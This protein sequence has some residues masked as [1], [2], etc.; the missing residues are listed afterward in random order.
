[1]EP[2]ISIVT[3]GVADMRRS[4]R[5]YREG[6]GF[7]TTARDDAGWAI[8]RTVGCRFALFPLTELAKDIAQGMNVTSGNFCGITLAHNVRS[9]LEV[10]AV[11]TL[12]KAAGARI[13]KPG[14][15]T[16]WGGYSGYFADPDG[17][18][19]EIAWGEMWTFAADGSLCGG[20]LGD[21][22]GT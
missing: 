11:L 4:I 15:P 13:L 19:W 16:S 12:A 2:R 10:D 14:Q 6:L 1:M 7:T 18:P 5:F 20:S 21:A 8:F 9:K 17:Y 22:K 3:L